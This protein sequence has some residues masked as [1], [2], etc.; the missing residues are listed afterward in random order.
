MNRVNRVNRILQLMDGLGSGPAA[1]GVSNEFADSVTRTF[2]DAGRSW[3]N[4]LPDTIARCVQ[5][6]DLTLEAPFEDLSFQYVIRARRADSSPVVL[7]LGVPRDELVGEVRALGLYAGRG[8]VQLIAWDHALGALLLERVEPGFQLAELANVD[9]L[10]ATRIGASAVRKLVSLGVTPETPSAGL[11]TFG[12]VERDWGHAFDG[13]HRLVRRD[14]GPLPADVL[15]DAERRFE[16][17]LTSGAGGDQI[18]LHGDLHHHN[19]LKSSLDDDTWIV[20]DPKGIVGEP[21]CEFASFLRNPGTVFAPDDFHAR[22]L[23]RRV[24]AIASITDLDLFRIRDWGVVGAVIS[25]IW[26]IEDGVTDQEPTVWQLPI[27][28]ARWL[29]ALRF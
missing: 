9:D 4:N 24:E 27:D 13:Y 29:A 25:A 20:I 21:G 15:I 22:T 26:C 18:M 3:L 2:G 19:I 12:S 10:T 23:H 1:P 7:K 8:V 11:T 17:L 28:C 16:R 5:V 14:T 6:W